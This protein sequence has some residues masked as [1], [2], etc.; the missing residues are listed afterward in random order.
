MR[1]RRL[2]QAASDIKNTNVKI[3]DIAIKYGYN[4]ANA[5]SSAYKTFHGVTPSDTRAS[6]VQP[7]SFQPLSFTLTLSVKGGNTMQY[8]KIENAEEFLQQMVNKEHSKKCLQSIS[9]NNGVK[10]V[11]DGIRSAVILPEGTADWDMSNAYIVTGEEERPKINLSDIFGRNVYCYNLNITKAQ[12]EN[13]LGCIEDYR[14][15]PDA[16]MPEIIFVDMNKAK[17]IKK[18]EAMELKNKAGECIMAFHPKYFKDTLDFIVCSDCDD[19]E[20]LWNDKTV[21]SYDDGKLWPL[22]M[23]SG[24]LYTA[25]L[26]FCI[27]SYLDGKFWW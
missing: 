7:K 6:G 12:A 10:C 22:I 15:K 17:F 2:T 23:K 4:S 5:F 21:A 26:P 8:R 19:I 24:C 11:L 27:D 25:L 20:V 16:L 14:M 13:L 3:I 1:K 9:E 18:S